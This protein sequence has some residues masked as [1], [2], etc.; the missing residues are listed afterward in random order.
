MVSARKEVVDRFVLQK[1]TTTDSHLIKYTRS[2]AQT[3][4]ERCGRRRAAACS[5]PE[6]RVLNREK[7]K[8]KKKKKRK[9]KQN[10]TGQKQV[11]LL[12]NY[13]TNMC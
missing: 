7:K 8:K 6:R 11:T 13:C 5:P 3:S 4:E 2:A 9:E 1:R 12:A 10:A